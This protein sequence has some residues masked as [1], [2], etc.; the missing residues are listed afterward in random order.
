MTRDEAIRRLIHDEGLEGAPFSTGYATA[1]V[2]SLEALGLLKLDTPESVHDEGVK[3]IA[4]MCR[5]WVNSLDGTK[6]AIEYDLRAA[7]LRIVSVA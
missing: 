7:K 4:K 1:L 6:E 2:T 5:Y 3:F